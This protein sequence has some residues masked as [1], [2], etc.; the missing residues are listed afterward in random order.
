MTTAQAEVSGIFI[1]KQRHT[2][3][4]PLIETEIIADWGLKDD[5][6]ARAGSS[7][8]VLLVDEA[9]LQSV[10]LQ[11]GDLNENLTIRGLD[12]NTLKPGQQV[13]IGDALLEVTGPCTVCGELEH[14]R[15]G[16]KERLRGRRG[17]L[18]RV[19]R[20]GTAKIGDSVW[21]EQ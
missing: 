7:R 20:S 14:I 19:L 11:P 17:M 13:R 2:A 12:V 10:D 3:M 5:R 9:T 1:S 8:Q 6:K 21:I 15:S 18:A 4:L 16:L